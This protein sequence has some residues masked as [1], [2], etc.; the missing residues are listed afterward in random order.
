VVHARRLGNAVDRA[1]QELPERQR[2]ALWLSAV[3]GFSYV[4]VAEALGTTEKS[5]KA[6]VHRARAA[7]ARQLP[8]EEIV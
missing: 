4:E 5:V 6:L 3:E 7:L 1:L 8:V 2:S